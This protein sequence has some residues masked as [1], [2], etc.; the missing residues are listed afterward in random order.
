M[1]QQDRGEIL[2]I[3][4]L[5]NAKIITFR[6]KTLTY[7]FQRLSVAIQRFDAVCVAGTLGD[8]LVTA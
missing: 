6:N 3:V 2:L 8:S 4:G 7:L 5:L 1:L